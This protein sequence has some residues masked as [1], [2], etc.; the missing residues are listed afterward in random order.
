MKL[1][2]TFEMKEKYIKMIKKQYP[3]LKI[4]HSDDLKE[5]KKEVVDA[6]IMISGGEARIELLNSAQ[7]LKWIQAWSAG[8]EGYMKEDV[9]S[10]LKEKDIKLSSMSGIHGNPIAEHVIGFIINFSHRFYDFYN[11]QKESRWEKIMPHQLAGKT[12]AVIGTGSIGRE[13]AR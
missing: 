4:V 10:M 3:E 11:L 6:D 1:L 2:I 8:V 7:H 5:Q 13:I 12:M 9:V